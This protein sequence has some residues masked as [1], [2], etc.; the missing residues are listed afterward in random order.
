MSMDTLSD[1]RFSVTDGSA[2]AG[3]DAAGTIVC[4]PLTDDPHIAN[5]GAFVVQ[6]RPGTSA[7]E[8]HAITRYIQ[9][10]VKG[11]CH[12][13]PNAPQRLDRSANERAKGAEPCLNR[14]FTEI[15]RQ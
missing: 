9:V 12:L 13:E 6:L 10:H 11:F 1:Y 8:T 15:H 5:C 7:A 14:A 2:G 4:E 3:D